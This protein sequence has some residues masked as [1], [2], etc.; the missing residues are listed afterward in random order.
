M[1]NNSEIDPLIIS[2]TQIISLKGHLEFMI[3][4]DNKHTKNKFNRFTTQIYKV[5]I[6]SN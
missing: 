5:R 1:D 4:M 3:M 6:K 2:R